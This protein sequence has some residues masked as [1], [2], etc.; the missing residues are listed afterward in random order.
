MLTEAM[1]IHTIMMRTQASA[2]SRFDVLPVSKVPPTG[3]FFAASGCQA[4]FRRSPHSS[5]ASQNASINFR[6]SHTTVK[7]RYQFTCL[8][9][10]YFHTGVCDA[11]IISCFGK[12]E[13]YYLSEYGG[14]GGYDII[15]QQ[16]RAAPLRQAGLVRAD[17][18]VARHGVV[19]LGSQDPRDKN[20]T[21]I[22]CHTTSSAWGHNRGY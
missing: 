16:P 20:T 5:L 15:V 19:L 18:Q 2:V 3:R 9:C 21:T 11:C 6:N 7:S 13:L 17:A 14:V 22:Q 1:S 8:I 12:H 10:V 4:I